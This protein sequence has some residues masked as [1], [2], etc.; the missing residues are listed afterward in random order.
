MA[1][2]FVAGPSVGGGAYWTVVGKPPGAALP[3][4]PLP[5]WSVSLR[6]PVVAATVRVGREECVSRGVSTLAARHPPL[7]TL[8]GISGGLHIGGD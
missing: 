7:V 3:P 8:G 6:R 4:Y 5:L 1:Q 2:R